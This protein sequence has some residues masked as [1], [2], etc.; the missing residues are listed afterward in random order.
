[1]QK[2]SAVLITLNAAQRLDATLQA[3]SWCDEIVVVDSGSSDNTLAICAH[4]QCR[5]VHRPF[6]RYG[7]QKKFAVDQAQHD[8]VL[9]VDSDEIV[10]DQLRQE[11]QAILQQNESKHAGYYVS[12][13]LIFLGTRLNSEASKRF[14]RFFNKRFGN[15]DDAPVHEKVRL[16]GSIGKLRGEMLHHSYRDLHEFFVK[17]NK[18]TSL[19][20]QSMHE[21]GRKIS[22]AHVVL[23][24]PVTF[25]KVYFI[26]GCFRNGVPG[27]L[28]AF[29]SSFYPV[30]KY[31]KL[32]E[33][34]L[35]K[36]PAATPQPS[37][38][39][40]MVSRPLQVIEK[41]S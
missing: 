10:T 6:D 37:I 16:T 11:I 36:A 29:L 5:V 30:V 38:T 41:S 4:Y 14:L 31:A 3:L 15:F 12:I 7:N 32:W 25:F 22:F 39:Q 1:M 34:N 33:L 26:K 13:P 24:C 28:W 18:Y 19:A 8:W 27:F 9:S 21:G 20:A 23:K 40:P 2:I 35:S 17:F